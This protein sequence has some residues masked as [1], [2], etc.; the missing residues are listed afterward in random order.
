MKT[1]NKFYNMVTVQKL[2][3][4]GDAVIWMFYGIYQQGNVFLY[5]EEGQERFKN[6][7]PPQKKGTFVHYRAVQSYNSL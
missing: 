4:F 5:W 2:A 6:L 7:P 3:L 1:I